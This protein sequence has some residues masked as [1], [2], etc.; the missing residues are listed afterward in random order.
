MTTSDLINQH[1]FYG[2]T[3]TPS[4]HQAV[5]NFVPAADDRALRTGSHRK[6][7]LKCQQLW[8]GDFFTLS[9]NCDKNPY[10]VIGEVWNEILN[11]ASLPRVV[12]L[13]FNMRCKM[14]AS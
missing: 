4:G 5:Q 13:I 1:L 11:L 7:C 14:A 12:N 3:L 6:Q 2:R 8:K 10:M 9:T